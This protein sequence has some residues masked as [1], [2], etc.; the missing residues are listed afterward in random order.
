LG[1]HVQT[2]AAAA[3]YVPG[4]HGVHALSPWS[5]AKVPA[6]QSVHALAAAAA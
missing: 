5:P 3:E 6:P 2:L 4:P 1:H